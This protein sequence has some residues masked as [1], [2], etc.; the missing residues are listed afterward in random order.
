MI[1]YLLWI[2]C[3]III[4][5]HDD[6]GIRNTILMQD[7]IGMA[8]IWLMSIVIIAI[9]TS[10]EYCPVLT[11]SKTANGTQQSETGKKKKTMRWYHYQ[12]KSEMKPLCAWGFYLSNIAL[13]L[14]EKIL[15][16]SRAESDFSLTMIVWEYTHLFWETRTPGLHVF[17][18]CTTR[19]ID[20]IKGMVS[21]FRRFERAIRDRLIFNC[22]CK[23]Y[24]EY[25]YS[26]ST[27]KDM[28]IAVLFS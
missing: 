17:C 14:F 28:T 3:N 13:S 22:Y 18:A 23:E 5:H 25:V 21:Q 26:S 16:M 20:L 7:L 9:G 10:N 2:V 19:I 15:P 6:V 8:N 1:D 27:S 24:Y 12:T 4:H 11:S